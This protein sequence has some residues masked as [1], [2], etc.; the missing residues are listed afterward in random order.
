MSIEYHESAWRCPN[1]TFLYNPVSR[2]KLGRH[3]RKCRKCGTKVK[4]EIGIFQV[5]RIEHVKC[6]ISPP[7]QE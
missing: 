5:E 7:I 3:V 2:Y 1:C 6:I 4:V